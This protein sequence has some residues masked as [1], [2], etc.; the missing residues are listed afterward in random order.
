[1]KNSI[2]VADDKANIVKSMRK[3]LEPYYEVTTATSGID[4]LDL[5]HDKQY[6]ALIIDV[7]FE[8]GMSGLETAKLLRETD[9]NIRIIIISAVDYSSATR[10]QA[11]S[12]GASFL[13][14]PLQVE[15]IRKIL[16]G[17]DG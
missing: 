7:I 17:S 13:E 1:M 4:V 14:K 15:H 3:M 6:D 2:I 8:G 16:E 12:I 11:I 10:Q 9:K 5:C